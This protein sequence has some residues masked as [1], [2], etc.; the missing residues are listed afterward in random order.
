MRVTATD[1]RGNTAHSSAR[2]TV[3]PCPG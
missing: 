3:T 1:S 2:L